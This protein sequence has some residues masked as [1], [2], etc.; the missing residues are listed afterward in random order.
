[1]AIRRQL[2]KMTLVATSNRPCTAVCIDRIHKNVDARVCA[3]AGVPIFYLPRNKQT[4][5]LL[6][7]KRTRIS[8][9]SPIQHYHAPTEEGRMCYSRLEGESANALL[10]IALAA[11][12]HV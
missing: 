11:C 5:N 7:K 3:C 8:M 6:Y 2:K 4:I 9:P 10:E 1:M 12:L